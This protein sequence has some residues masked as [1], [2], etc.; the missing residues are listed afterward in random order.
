MY[1]SQSVAV[2]TGYVLT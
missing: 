2:Y 1:I